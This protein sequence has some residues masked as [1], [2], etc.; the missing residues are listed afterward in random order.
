MT[1]QDDMDAMLVLAQANVDKFLGGHA[2]ADIA[3]LF[4]EAP[5]LHKMMCNSVPMKVIIGL[6]GILISK[7]FDL[8]NPPG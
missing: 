1:T 6:L 2:D 3:K 5:T 8:Q 4:N 7:V